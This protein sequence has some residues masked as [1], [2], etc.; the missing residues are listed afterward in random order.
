MLHARLDNDSAAGIHLRSLQAAPPPT[1]PAANAPALQPLQGR[2][3]ELPPQLSALASRLPAPRFARRLGP[4]LSACPV[5]RRQVPST[6]CVSSPPPS[7]KP[8][9]P[10]AC[11]SAVT[12]ADHRRFI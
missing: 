12:D 3:D 11:C 5:A 8:S 6:W 9:P 10:P 7:M 2:H 4:R 1:A